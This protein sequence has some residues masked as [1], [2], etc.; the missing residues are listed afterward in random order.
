MGHSL[1]ISVRL[2]R[3]S[4]IEMSSHVPFVWM[5]LHFY[6][7]HMEPVW[8]N[9]S[10]TGCMPPVNSQPFSYLP[11]KLWL[12]VSHMGHTA[13]R[14][15]PHSISSLQLTFCFVSVHLLFIRQLLALDFSQ[16]LAV[17][18]LHTNSANGL[19]L[20]RLSGENRIHMGAVIENVWFITK[21]WWG[22]ASK[23]EHFFWNGTWN[24]VLEVG[25]ILGACLLFAIRTLTYL[26]ARAYCCG[27]ITAGL[28][29]FKTWSFRLILTTCQKVA[30]T[31]VYILYIIVLQFYMYY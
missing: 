24:F 5:V 6:H 17:S 28:R 22:V 27:T 25:R 1:I 9:R 7:S 10:R 18:G 12:Y 15:L 3:S 2:L 23:Q 26:C 8:P 29:N 13:T 20:N 4:Q 30:L 16:T 21:C 11:Q 19:S 14:V 31:T